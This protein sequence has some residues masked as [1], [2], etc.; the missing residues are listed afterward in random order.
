M[1]SVCISNN[2]YPR[3]FIEVLKQLHRYIQN[4]SYLLQ[5][6]IVNF[7]F[8]FKQRNS[9]LQGPPFCH[10]LNPLTAI[11]RS[12]AL[13]AGVPPIIASLDVAVGELVA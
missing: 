12:L 7:F 2:V 11:V 13:R 10:S 9:A 4:L 5:Q 3:L 8:L 1:I 6:R